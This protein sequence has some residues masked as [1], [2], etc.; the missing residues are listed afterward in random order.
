MPPKGWKKGSQPKVTGTTPAPQVKVEKKGPKMRAATAAPAIPEQLVK[1][2]KAE[3]G[4]P[5]YTAPPVSIPER[6]HI[7]NATLLTFAS[8]IATQNLSA[9]AAAALND[10]IVATIDAIADLRDALI[11]PKISVE[12]PEIVIQ[13]PAPVA[14]TKPKAER[15][16]AQMAPPPPMPFPAPPGPHGIQQPPMQGFIPVV[17]GR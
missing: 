17:A 3:A 13:Q 10:E 7:L 5:G 9:D 4:N 16:P 1:H 8:A 15:A 12:A 6:I 2:T 14:Q 11:P